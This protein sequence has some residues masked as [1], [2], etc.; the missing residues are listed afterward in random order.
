VQGKHLL[1]GHVVCSITCAGFCTLSYVV[2]GGKSVLACGDGLTSQALCFWLGW[3]RESLRTG[4]PSRWP[5]APVVFTKQ[6]RR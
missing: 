2:I 6:T 3:V 5:S 4:S 1:L